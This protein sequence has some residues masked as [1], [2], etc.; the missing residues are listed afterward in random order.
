VPAQR[1]NLGARPTRVATLALAA[2]LACLALGPADA[3]AQAWVPEP[4]AGY[5]KGGIRW[6]PGLGHHPVA[7]DG[8]AP[9]VTV[10]QPFGAYNELFVVVYGELGVAPGVAAFLSAQALRIFVVPDPRGGAT[11]VHVSPGEPQLGFRFKLVRHRRFALALEAHVRAPIGSGRP[12]QPIYAA[13]QGH[14]EIGQLTVAT[15]VWEGGATLVAGLGFDRLWLV[16]G[17]GLTAAGG[18]WDRVL[19]WYVKLGRPLKRDW[20]VRVRLAGRHPLGDGEARYHNS[21]SGIGNGTRYL[22]LNAEFVKH[23]ERGPSFGLSVS[24]AFATSMRQ[25]S[26]PVVQVFLEHGW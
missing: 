6:L 20:E 5:V 13:A 21:P 12:V 23:F 4:G 18:G 14:E 16:A 7:D 9:F 25:T 22:A 19:E 17:V 26:G 15:G 2:L 10:P 8:P 3:W 11:Q 1:P 24:G